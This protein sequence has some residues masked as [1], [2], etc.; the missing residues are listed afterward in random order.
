MRLPARGPWRQ[1]HRALVW[2]AW[3]A[4]GCSRRLS[5]RP[6][7]AAAAGLCPIVSQARSRS[8][9]QRCP[10]RPGS[11]RQ[12]CAVGD[13]M[14]R[15]LRRV[16][17]AFAANLD[18]ALPFE[19]QHMPAS[20]PTKSSAADRE[21]SGEAEMIKPYMALRSRVGVTRILSLSACSVCRRDAAALADGTSRS[22][23]RCRWALSRTRT[24]SASPPRWV[25]AASSRSAAARLL[26]RSMGRMALVYSLRTDG[27]TRVVIPSCVGRAS[28]PRGLRLNRLRFW[29][30]IKTDVCLR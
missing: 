8:P 24:L 11:P 27:T 29:S 12:A 20:H 7:P 25:P 6:R 21:G 19:S 17:L 9:V 26:A 10:A 5:R 13:W 18:P 2:T 15:D 1:R 3:S 22:V 16:T 30:V 4:E 14:A 23:P 28:S